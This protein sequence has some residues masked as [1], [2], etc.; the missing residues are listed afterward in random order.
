MPLY[1]RARKPQP[2]HNPGE[3]AIEAAIGRRSD[4][5]R[6][7]RFELAALRDVYSPI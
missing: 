2:T 6:L 5:N 1:H 7:A 4:F 3:Y